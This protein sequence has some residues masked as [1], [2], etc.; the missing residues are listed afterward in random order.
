MHVTGA[1]T[2]K[3]RFGWVGPLVRNFFHGVAEH[4]RTNY[5]RKLRNAL[6]VRRPVCT[7]PNSAWPCWPGVRVV[8]VPD[9]P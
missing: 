6:P 5:I 7:V 2:R 9:D 8:V 1:S 3:K 4:V